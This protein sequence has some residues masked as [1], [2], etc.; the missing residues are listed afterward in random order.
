MSVD[1]KTISAQL[2]VAPQ[3]TPSEVTALKAQ[4]FRTI[5]CNRRDGEAPDQPGF[6]QIADAAHA[7]GLEVRNIPVVGSTFSSDDIARFAAALNELPQPVLAY[8]RS[9]TRSIM[10]WALSQADQMPVADILKVAQKA[11]YDLRD[12]MR[13]VANR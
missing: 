5:I 10:L 3:I 1:P 4:G 13:N 7:A 2:S 11:G 12:V 9:G 8:C 6:A